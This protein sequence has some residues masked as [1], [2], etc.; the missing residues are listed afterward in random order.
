MF[1]SKYPNYKLPQYWSH[2][3]SWSS[4]EISARTCELCALVKNESERP[5]TAHENDVM[6]T[7]I[8]D[9]PQS[10]AIR[11]A[12]YAGGRLEFMCNSPVK[13]VRLVVALDDG[14]DSQE[15]L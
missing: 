6:D 15:S 2:Q 11:C 13:F 9:I 3:P 10:P 7:A 14:I 1:E 5:K 12:G 8:S 4:L